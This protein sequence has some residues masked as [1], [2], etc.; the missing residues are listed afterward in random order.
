MSGH[1]PGPWTRDYF[2]QIAFC[3]NSV[4]LAHDLLHFECLQCRPIGYY[5]LIEVDNEV[6]L[7][8]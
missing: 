3:H 8:C 4:Q 2:R 1:V 6:Q 5:N 7:R